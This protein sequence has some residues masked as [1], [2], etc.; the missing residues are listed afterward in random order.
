[1]HKL[2]KRQVAVNQRI[3]CASDLGGLGVDMTARHD[4]LHIWVALWGTCLTQQ[5]GSNNTH[6]RTYTQTHAYTWRYIYIYVYRYTWTYIHMC[7]YI[8]LYIHVC[9]HRDGGRERERERESV[10]E[11]ASDTGPRITWAFTWHLKHDRVQWVG[12]VSL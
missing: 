12:M 8:Y 1:M 11:R 7:V 4:C 3:A 6:I 9:I 5:L 2:M 10:C